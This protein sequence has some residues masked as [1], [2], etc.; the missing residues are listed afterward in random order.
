MGEAETPQYRHRFIVEAYLDRVFVARQVVYRD[1]VKDGS[2]GITVP[3]SMKLHARFYEIAVW[4]D[5]VPLLMRKMVER[6]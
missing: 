1:V 3:V 6:C 4:A 2:E 5:Y